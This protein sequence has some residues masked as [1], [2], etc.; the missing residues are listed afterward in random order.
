VFAVD[1]GVE[2]VVRRAARIAAAAS[3]AILEGYARMPARYERFI[4]AHVRRA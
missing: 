2:P 1:H 3:N 4:A